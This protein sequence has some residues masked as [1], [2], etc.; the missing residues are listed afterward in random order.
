MD[1]WFDPA[2]AKTTA[3]LLQHNNLMTL[4]YEVMWLI[5]KNSKFLF[6]I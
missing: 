2:I 3:K 6:D 1:W 5:T 4:L